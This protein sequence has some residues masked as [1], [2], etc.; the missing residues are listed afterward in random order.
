M[1]PEAS[2]RLRETLP[3]EEVPANGESVAGAN[4]GRCMMSIEEVRPGMLSV[5]YAVA[6]TLAPVAG[7]VTEPEPMGANRRSA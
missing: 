1:A 5:V 3:I 6:V 7:S 2:R 4:A